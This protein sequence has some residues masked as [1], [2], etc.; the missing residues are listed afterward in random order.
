[1]KWKI[2]QSIFIISLLLMGLNVHSQPPP[3]SGWTNV[4]ADEFGG[5]SVNTN[6]WNVRNDVAFKPNKAE[7]N[8]GTL[9]IR[10]TFTSNSVSQ[11]GWLESKTGFSGNNRYGYYEARLR[12]D[13]PDRGDIWPTW[14]IWGKNF[15]NGAPGP[16]GTEFDLMEYSGFGKKFF[17]GATTSHHYFDKRNINGKSNIT[18]TRASTESRNAF[19]WHVW[20]M[21]W[22][23]TKIDF[24]Y[25][26]VKY[27]SSDQPAD[28]ANDPF[29][30][31]LIFS[32]S[33]HTRN[34]QNANQ[35]FGGFQPSN[36]P[37]FAAVPGRSLASLEVDWVRVWRGGTIE[38]TGGGS[39]TNVTFRGQGINTYVSSENGIGPITCN[40][41]NPGAWEVFTVKS[42]G[43]G[44][45][46]I[47]GNNGRYISSEDGLQA[48][49]CSRV[50]V[51]AWEKFTLVSQGGNVY[52]IRGNNGKYVSHE[53][54]NG[55]MN[56][57]RNVI[58]AW[59]KF[60]IAGLN[61][62]K[63]LSIE[64]PELKNTISFYPNPSTVDNLNLEISTSK[65]VNSTSLEIADLTGKI[66][67]SEKLGSLEAGRNSVS[68]SHVKGLLRIGL[69]IAK[70]T[71]DNEVNMTK[72]MIE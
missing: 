22:T 59:E 25:D 41:A 29:P 12:I 44:Q 34:V 17:G 32:S 2:T 24:Y 31:Y 48:M 27:M 20:G 37:E 19:Q 47:Q 5:S 72:I 4:F 49:T 3:G 7:V 36:V 57:N 15:R 46:S 33:P 52:A 50:S 28:A 67:A 66:V 26:G 40:R 8:G 61:N 38:N 13:G 14:W 64:K 1:M 9:K 65:N 10:N 11:G 21:H 18:S 56:C 60:T 35:D 62:N 42:E 16:S 30:L 39:D 55:P 69:Y 51:G 53:N 71:L 23:P 68:L 6:I 43:N 54:G 45:V 70:V 63:S 58:G